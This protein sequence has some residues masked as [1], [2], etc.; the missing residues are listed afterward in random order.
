MVY[1]WSSNCLYVRSMVAEYVT[2]EDRFR[3]SYQQRLARVQHELEVA[4]MTKQQEAL[5]AEHHRKVACEER[6]AW[7]E[8][9]LCMSL[10]WSGDPKWYTNGFRG[11]QNLW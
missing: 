7:Q 3:V 9:R 2:M 4:E 11:L 5:E 10:T 1:K 6:V 8:L